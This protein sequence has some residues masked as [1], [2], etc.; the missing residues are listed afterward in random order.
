M[1]AEARQMMKHLHEA[2]ALLYGPRW[3]SDLG[4]ALNVSDRSVRRWLA[5]EHALP[6]DMSSQLRKLI[7]ERIAALRKV[8][9]KLPT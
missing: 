1:E 7:D 9:H 3:Q 2:A 4:R 8:R 6:E 5:E